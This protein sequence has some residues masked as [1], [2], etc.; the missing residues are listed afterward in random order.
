MVKK[1]IERIFIICLIS[2]SFFY[3][4]KVIN[5]I[6]HNDPLMKEIESLKSEY[7]VLPVN[8]ILDND[9]I[10]PGMKGKEVD[11]DKS[12]ENM[13]IG[14]ILRE[15]ALVFKNL[16][17]NNSINNNL[18]KYIVKG[19]NNKKEV[20]IIIILN[21]NINEIK[22]IDNV[23]IFINHKDLTTGNI[24]L[25][26]DKEIYTYGN[27]GIYNK[28]ILT[29]DNTL[30]NRLSNNKSKYCLVREKNDNI[31]KLCSENDMYTVIPNI[32]GDYYNIK[33]NLSNG[34]IILLNNI[35]NIDIIIKYIK[36]K[37][38]EIVSLNKLLSE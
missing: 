21:N 6:N 33:N 24:K 25:L 19:S 17:P 11:V 15:D 37:G 1:F 3:T 30:I 9:T 35:N 8:A 26:K 18:D 4:D 28:E 34:S 36:S 16:Y 38:Y 13:K 2:F 29:N 5:M 22:K 32:Y 14:G 10:I 7:D 12:Y 27:N 31:L 23:T 20:S